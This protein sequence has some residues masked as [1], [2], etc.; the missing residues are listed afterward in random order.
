MTKKVDRRISLDQVIRFDEKAKEI[1]DVL[2]RY[3][4]RMDREIILRNCL[5]AFSKN[6]IF[7][8]QGKPEFDYPADPEKWL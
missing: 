6:E 7:R 5:S 1:L 2:E 4:A 3:P 8:S